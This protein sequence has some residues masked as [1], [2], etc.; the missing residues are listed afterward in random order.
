MNSNLVCAETTLKG[1]LIF[2]LYTFIGEISW[3]FLVNKQ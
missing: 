1:S 3:N 2:E